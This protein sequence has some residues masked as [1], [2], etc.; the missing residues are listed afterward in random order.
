MAKIKTSRNIILSIKDYLEPLLI[1]KEYDFKFVSRWLDD[2]YIVLPTDF[3]DVNT[4]IRLPAGKLTITN[5]LPG[6]F[7]EIGANSQERFYSISLFFYSITEG[8]YL[9]LSDY[10]SDWLANGEEADRIGSNSIEIKNYSDT[11][12]PSES[13]PNLCYMDILNV[14]ARPVAQIETPNIALRNAGNISFTGKIL[15]TF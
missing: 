7:Y 10:I 9:D 3:I 6:S 14:Q 11:G 4:Q 13:A 12:Y 1:N 8:Q 15:K 2:Q 5:Q